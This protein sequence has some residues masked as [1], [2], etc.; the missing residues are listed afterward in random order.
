MAEVCVVNASPLIFLSRGGHLPL[1]RIVAARALVP[2][3]VAE[4]LRARGADD[5][6]AGQLDAHPWLAIMEPSQPPAARPVMEDLLRGGMFLSRP[7]LDR[8][9]AL[10]GE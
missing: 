2:N 4:E 5:I 3:A 6:T 9:L 8:A 1:L 7:L 10:V